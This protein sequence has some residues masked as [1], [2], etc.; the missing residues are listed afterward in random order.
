MQLS[1]QD[2]SGLTI[3]VELAY[4]IVCLMPIGDVHVKAGNHGSFSG[5]L[6]KDMKQ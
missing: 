3:Y 4:F 5:N 6:G 2:S 1:Y